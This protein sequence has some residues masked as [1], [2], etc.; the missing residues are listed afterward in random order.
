M[1]SDIEYGGTDLG[2]RIAEH[3]GRAGLSR[4]EAAERAGMAPNYLAYLETSTTPNPSQGALVRLSAALQVPASALSGAG[5]SLPPGQR[6]AA[7]HPALD[8]LSAAECREYLA[9]GGI[10][11]FL[12]VDARGPVAMPVNY[13]ML[14]DDIVFRTGGHT[15]LV[16]G[17]EQQKVSFDVDHFDEALSEGWSVLAHGAATLITAL[18]ELEQARSLRIDPWAGGDRDTYVRIVTAEISGRRIRVTR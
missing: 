12:F 8:V 17:V 15:S 16:A 14:G 4:D 2:R 9:T 10:G 11:R 18:A 1:G 13:A 5:L 6:G 7:R 3:R